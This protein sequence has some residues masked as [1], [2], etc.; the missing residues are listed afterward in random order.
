MHLNLLSMKSVSS[1]LSLTLFLASTG[2]QKYCDEFEPDLSYFPNPCMTKSRPSA[3]DPLSPAECQRDWGKELRIGYA[4]ANEQD[5]YRAITA[6]KRTLVLLPLKER[7]RLEQV[8]YAIFQCYYFA[9][10]YT[11][12][13]EAFEEGPL[14]NVSR[15]FPAFRELLIMLYDCYQKTGNDAKAYRILSLIDSEFPCDAADL[16]LSKAFHEADFC[17]ISEKAACTSYKEET[18]QLL[19]DYSRVAKSPRLARNYQALLP[20]AGYY[21]VGLKDTAVTSLLLNTFF[22]WAAYS[23]FNNGNIAAG[24]ITTSLEAGWYFGGINGAGIA[25]REYNER[26]YELNGREFMRS[27]SLYPIL[28]LETT[29]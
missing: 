10:K 15:S 4:F 7:A 2:C 14:Q 28:R 20:G 19:W 12:A 25:A 29:F 23:F 9:Y 8:H 27:R 18:D 11:E 1:L 24:V 17:S 26:L 6:F 3:F 16:S 21:Y 5:Y 13:M 22:I